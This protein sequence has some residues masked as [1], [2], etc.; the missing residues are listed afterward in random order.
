[1]LLPLMYCEG[2]YC[3]S[4]SMRDED[5]LPEYLGKQRG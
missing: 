5:Y 4:F 3:L 2:G 1:M